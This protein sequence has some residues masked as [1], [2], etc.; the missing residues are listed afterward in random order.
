MVLDVLT[1][2]GE[3]LITTYQ[4]FLLPYL[5]KFKKP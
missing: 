5:V 3:I 1:V 4:G 2:V